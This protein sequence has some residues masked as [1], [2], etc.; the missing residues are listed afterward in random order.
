[1]RSIGFAIL[2]G[3]LLA[4]PP[5]SPSDPPDSPSH[6]VG[7]L[8]A[9]SPG[10]VLEIRLR[11]GAGLH[12]TA[13]DRDQISVESDWTEERC[14][15]AR[16]ELTRVSGG[17][18]LA[19]YYPD[20]HLEVNHN[21]SFSIQVRVPRRFDLRI[22]S[23]GGGVRITGLNGRVSGRTGGGRIAL[24]RLNGEVQLSTGGGEIHVSDSDLDGRLSTGGGRIRF[25]R[26]SGPV[27]ARSGSVRGVVRGS[28]GRET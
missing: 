3:T 12:I 22:R 25:E 17:A 11:T 8:D 20:D 9:V 4:V 1:M 15:D 6:F 27:T 21:C 10:Q 26:V 23:A 5:A 19:S 28:V 7:M 2:A 18:L 16:I 24:E 14:R 13:W